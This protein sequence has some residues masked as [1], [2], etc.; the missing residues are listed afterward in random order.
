MFQTIWQ[1]GLQ[2]DQLL[3]KDLHDQFKKWLIDLS[4]L[5]QWSIPRCLF[6]IHWSKKPKLAV[7]GF[8]DASEHA[9]GACV[10]LVA[11]R[12]T[13]EFESALVISKAR[14]APLKKITLPRLE[15]LGALICARLV[16]YVKSE[17]RLDQNVQTYCW[18]DSTVALSW[19]K[20]DPAKWKTFIC[21]RVTEIQGLVEPSL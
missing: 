4:V 19:I 1:Q 15:L 10:Y 16:S 6:S 8:G 17:L 13:G 9:Y 7:H 2:W 18:T 3:P 5:R 14:V 21:N 12:E 11:K 20:S